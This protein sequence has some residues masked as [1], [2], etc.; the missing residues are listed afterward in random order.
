MPMSSNFPPPIFRPADLPYGAK[1]PPEPP[2]PYAAVVF[3]KRRLEW[4]ERRK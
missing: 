2:I 3:V 1:S 4:R